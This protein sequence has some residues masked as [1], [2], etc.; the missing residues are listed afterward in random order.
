MVDKQDAGAHKDM[1]YTTMLNSIK[2]LR[3]YFVRLALLGF[4]NVLP[5]INYIQELGIEAEKSMMR[6]TNNVNTHRGAL[7]CMEFGC[8]FVCKYLL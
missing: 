2:T 6:A 8:C 1:D 5:E 3:P 7:F 4:N